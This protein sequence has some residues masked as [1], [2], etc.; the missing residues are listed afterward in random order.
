MII[1]SIQ[2]DYTAAHWHKNTVDQQR[3]VLHTGGFACVD[4]L[5]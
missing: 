1:I 5:T 2:P 3:R 4:M